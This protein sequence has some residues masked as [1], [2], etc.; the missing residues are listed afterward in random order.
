MSTVLKTWRHEAQIDAETAANLAGVSLPTWSRWE[1]GGRQI[2]ASR[3]LDVEKLTGVSRHDL[4]PDVFGDTPTRL[5]RRR[6][7]QEASA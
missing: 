2:P 5:P 6:Q 7:P 3:V 1:T 4:R